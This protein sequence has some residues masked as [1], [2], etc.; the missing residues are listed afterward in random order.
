MMGSTRFSFIIP[1]YNA[2]KTIKKCLLSVVDQLYSNWEAIVID[3]GS[4][5]TT[6]NILKEMVS[7]NRIR[8]FHQE[9]A[10]PGIS[11]NNAL[12]YVSGDYIVFLDSDDY[13]ENTYLLTV[14][15]IIENTNAD[16]IVLDNY[17]ETID[18]RIIREERL[19]KYSNFSKWDLI[20][21]QM[22]GKMPWGGWRKVIQRKLIVENNILYSEDT[23][24]EE[25]IF[26]FKVFYYADKIEF[27]K[28]LL[29]HYVDMPASQ[30][31]KGMDEPWKSVVEQ[32]KRF[33]QEEKLFE[34]YRKEWNS[35]AASSLIVSLYRTSCNYPLAE[36]IQKCKQMIKIY[37]KNNIYEYCKIS[38]ENRVIL[39][40]FFVK[41]NSVFPIV[42]ISKLK[43][44][45][46]EMIK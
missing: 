26:S 13:I 18:G 9:N 40:L 10:G 41:I 31:K 34:V 11:R 21:I 17:Y 22:T 5:D 33:L 44:R 30:S 16:V 7:D 36:A 45:I 15:G 24:G 39:L 35:F 12:K 46:S 38:L 2:E 4:N 42:C 43:K 3:D 6:Y 29:Y 23:V 19:S 1:A 14:E 37:K 27:A 8:V 20:A 32:M 25:A 28:K